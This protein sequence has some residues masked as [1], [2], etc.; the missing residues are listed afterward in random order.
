MGRSSMGANLGAK[1]LRTRWLVR[2]PILLYRAG[3]GFLFG[4]RLLMLEHL[5]RSSGRRRYVV[6]EVV[7]HPA[8]TEYVIVSGFGVGAQWYRN[9][10]THP[11]VRVSTGFRRRLPATATPMTETDSAHALE[12]YARQHPRAWK[13]LRATIEQATGAPVDTLPMVRLRVR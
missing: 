5:G 3:F 2:A 6:L 10:V 1:A 9:I 7:D 13:Q 4:R 12:R 11:A 8:A